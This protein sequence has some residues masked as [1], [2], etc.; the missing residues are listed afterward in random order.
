MLHEGS[1]HSW[2]I[3][4]AHVEAEDVDLDGEERDS[5]DAQAKQ[6]ILLVFAGC[7]TGCDLSRGRGQLYRSREVRY[8]ARPS[9]DE[10]VPVRIE[11]DLRLAR[12]DFDDLLS[13]QDVR[14]SVC[15]CI[16]PISSVCFVV[17]SERNKYE[18]QSDAACDADG[19]D[20]HPPLTEGVVRLSSLFA[21]QVVERVA[22]A[23]D[24]EFFWDLSI[25]P[26]PFSRL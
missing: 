17:A 14:I 12:L 3:Y 24:L 25:S 2:Q 21:F 13:I 7:C 23:V 1:L 10:L 5:A 11:L 19:A 9:L 22:D 16:Q 15:G 20:E 8:G 4:G 6:S 18:L 26:P